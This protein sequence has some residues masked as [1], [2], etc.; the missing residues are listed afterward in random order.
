MTVNSW[1]AMTESRIFS[2]F[3]FAV[4][5]LY[6]DCFIIIC[7]T[8]YESKFHISVKIFHKPL[9]LVFFK[10]IFFTI[11]FIFDH[12]FIIIINKEKRIS[13]LEVVK[14]VYDSFLLLVCWKENSP[15]LKIFFRKQWNEG[16]LHWYG[17]QCY[18]DAKVIRRICLS[19]NSHRKPRNVNSEES[20]IR[21]TL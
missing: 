15:L 12:I 21:C 13:P 6:V 18:R 5:K 7:L 10:N 16:G 2:S 20:K 3:T 14:P 19:G 17:A 4:Y 11:I 9:L 8:K 1:G